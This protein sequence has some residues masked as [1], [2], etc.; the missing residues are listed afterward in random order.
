MTRYVQNATNP[1]PS[2]QKE[3]VLEKDIENLM[4]NFTNI[5]ADCFLGDKYA[6]VGGWQCI[7]WAR[8]VV[9][10]LWIYYTNPTYIILQGIFLESEDNLLLFIIIS[11]YLARTT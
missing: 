3:F 10:L 7:L 5:S 4:I 11:I 6:D 8:L 2:R 1:T 9:A